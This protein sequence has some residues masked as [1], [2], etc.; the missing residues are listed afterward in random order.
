MAAPTLK[1]ELMVPINIVYLFFTVI[2]LISIALFFP[3]KMDWCEGE[4]QR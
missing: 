3:K 1:Q 4:D 2:I